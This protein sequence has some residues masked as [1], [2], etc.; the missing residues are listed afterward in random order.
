M[1]IVSFYIRGDAGRLERNNFRLDQSLELL[2]ERY[3]TDISG[4]QF[5]ALKGD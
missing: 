3:N 1:D 2:S 4:I 5:L